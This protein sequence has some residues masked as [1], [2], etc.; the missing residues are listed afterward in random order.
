MWQPIKVMPTPSRTLDGLIEHSKMEF[1][2]VKGGFFDGS[3]MQR[4]N[5]NVEVKDFLIGTSEVTVGQYLLFIDSLPFLMVEEY[6]NRGIPVEDIPSNAIVT[7]IRYSEVCLLYT[8]PSPRD[9]S[10]S[11]MPSSA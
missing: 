4:S 10:T 8:S 2:L 5:T 7:H 6:E 11:R 1:E 3:A 9:L